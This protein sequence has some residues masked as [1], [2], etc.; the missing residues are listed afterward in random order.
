MG[1]RVI[2]TVRA[3]RDL[4][5]AVSFL[6][7]NSSEAAERIGLE[8]IAVARS[9]TTLPRRG[10]RVRKRPGLRKLTHRHYL[11]FYQINEALSSV[12][13]VRIWDGRQDPETLQLP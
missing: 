7:Q 13:I 4:E 6:A 3:D 11:L 5:A 12:E 10:G 8:I 9:L 2:F 1:Y